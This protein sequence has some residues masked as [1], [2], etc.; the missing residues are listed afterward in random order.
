MLGSAAFARDAICF[1]HGEPALYQASSVCDRGFCATCGSSLFTSY[2]S[3][4]VFDNV[5]F[6]GLGTLDDP[7]IA[8]PSMH[9]GAEGELSWMHRDDGLPRIRIDVDDPGDQNALFERM[10][11]EA[12]AKL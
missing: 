7:E 3:G 6:V 2:H 4:G 9:Y 10:V 5:Y 1:T 8:R 12:K 11:A